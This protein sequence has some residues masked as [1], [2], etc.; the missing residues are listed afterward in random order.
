MRLNS[1]PLISFALSL[2]VVLIGGLMNFT[3]ANAVSPHFLRIPFDNVNNPL[4]LYYYFDHNYPNYV[5]DGEI[6]VYTGESV[7]EYEPYAYHGHSGY[8]WP[9]N[10]GTP[11]L[12]A[13]SGIVDDI[14]ED[15]NYGRYITID[16]QNGY[17]TLY[18]HMESFYVDEGEYVVTGALIGQS[19]NTGLHTTGPHL[20]FGVYIGDCQINNESNATDP[21]GWT[22]Q[23]SDPLLQFGIH[24]TAE[25]LWRS[26]LSDA[27]SCTDTIVEDQSEHFSLGAGTTWYESTI[28]NG[29]HMYYHN[30]TTTGY[31]VDWYFPLDKSGI[32][33]IYAWI[34]INYAWSNQ[35]K[36]YIH[37]GY[38][39]E[40]VTI[41][42]QIFENEW[43]Y[44][45]TFKLLSG[46]PGVAL[47]ANTGEPTSVV[48]GVDAVKIRVAPIFLPIVFYGEDL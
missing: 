48:I 4:P 9:L 16:H 2:L 3:M 45:G 5:Q 33:Q 23:G 43:V 38:S 13:A 20:H 14:D 18:A 37:T 15:L 8:D 31:W 12:A 21:F 26:Y 40:V 41:N 46:W 10:W 7:D 42:Q 6:T 17:E 34:P 22:G 25:C 11:V 27:I 35:A 29:L 19:G 47:N 32:F 44:L 39:I 36:Y 30:V 1:L 24:H 28:G